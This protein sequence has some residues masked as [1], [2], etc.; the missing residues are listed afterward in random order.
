MYHS[1]IHTVVILG[2][3]NLAWHFG[4]RLSGAG[5]QVRQVFSRTPKQG[6]SLASEL[7][8]GYT[9]R[10]DLLAEDADLYLLAV[11]DDAI[12][13]LLRQA[14]FGKRLVAHAAG[15]VS[16][17][18]FAGKVKNYGVLYPLQT[19]TQGKPLDF[20]NIPLFIEAN[21]ARNLEKLNRLACR[22]SE[23]VYIVDSEKRTYLHLAAVIASNFTNHMF[24]LAEKLMQERNLSFDI[25]K[26]LIQETVA[27]AL[28]ISPF[29]SQT[30]PAIRGNAQVIEKHMAMLEHHPEIRELYRMISESIMAMNNEQ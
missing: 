5:I 30:G 4:H 10:L 11:S 26:P 25:L 22:L 14:R 28:Q 27:K 9:N 7:N 15:S 6:E 1:D 23:R 3:G 18:V 8:T 20:S 21:N 24:T 2:A 13:S 17:D 12:A 19:F 16:I 29:L